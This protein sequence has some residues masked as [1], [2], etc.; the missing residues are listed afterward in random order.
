MG[1][2]SSP[3]ALLNSD[4][5][6]VSDVPNT[7]RDSVQFDLTYTTEE[8]EALPFRLMDTAR[9]R[10]KNKV[11]TS[12]DYFSTLRT[13]QAIEDGDL[14]FLIVD[15]KEGIGKLEKRL[16]GQILEQ[17]KCLAILVNKWDLAQDQFEED[18]IEGYASLEEFQGAF[19]KALHKELFFLPK[20]PVYFISAQ[21][22]FQIDK[23]LKEA[24]AL[25]LR[26][27]GDPNR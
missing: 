16:A 13:H 10:T 18:D 19:L 27:N 1:K 9:V 12:L 3:N 14:V 4:R 5:M 25:Y 17:G 7:T 23:V 21:T 6:I 15:A 11:N 22:G 26:A 24:H 20:S 2:S 8:G